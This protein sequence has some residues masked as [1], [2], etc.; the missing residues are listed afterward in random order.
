MDI[1]SR[2]SRVNGF[3]PISDRR[4]GSRR[5]GVALARCA[6]LRSCSRA[7]VP[8]LRLAGQDAAIEFVDDAS[9]IGASFVV[10]RNAVILVDRIGAGVIGGQR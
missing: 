6:R 5:F 3:I 7:G 8:R 2:L 1:R 10:R 9:D 4:E